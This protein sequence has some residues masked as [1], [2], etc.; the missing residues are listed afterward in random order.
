MS[1]EVYKLRIRGEVKYAV[2]LGNG[3]VVLHTLK[4]WI[5]L[6]HGVDL[7]AARQ[8]DASLEIE[9]ETEDQ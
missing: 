3:V 6:V 7:D 4:E 8:H 1:T 2:P 5:D 9:P